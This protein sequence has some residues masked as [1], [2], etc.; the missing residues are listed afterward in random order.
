[1]RRSTA[2]K[3]L[4][5]VREDWEDIGTM[6][7]LWG[8]YS[9]PEGQFGQWDTAA[10]FETG[11]Q[12]VAALMAKLEA[13]D[14]P[15]RRAQALDFGCGVGRLTRALGARFGHV[16]GVDVSAPM[17][18]RARQLNA[19]HPACEFVTNT[20]DRLGF[21]P[22]GHV[23]LVYTRIVLQHLGSRPLIKRYI[24]ELLRTVRHDGILVFQV[25]T[26][27]P[28]WRRI[29]IR[30]RAYVLL[31][32]AGLPRELL[33]ERLRLMPFTATHISEREVLAAVA[34]MGGRVLRVEPEPVGRSGVESRIFY[35]AAGDRAPQQ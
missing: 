12:E 34:A 18:D 28:V 33:Y 31:H 27:I 2:D 30:H 10:F 15:A 11:E 16:Y 14:R 5:A 3:A 29:Q 24:A 8:V 13:F 35:V 17:V 26:H 19:E 20:E 7:P 25:L 6:D 22:D 21:V 4:R 9:T 32:A 23:D 1:M